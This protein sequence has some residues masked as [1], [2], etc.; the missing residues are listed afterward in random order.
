MD[1][2]GGVGRSEG[3]RGGVGVPNDADSFGL[4][5][6]ATHIHGIL[7]NRDTMW[8]A[9]SRSRAQVPPPDPIPADKF[10]DSFSE[11]MDNMAS[12]ATNEKAVLE[13]LFTKTTTQYAAI[14]ALLK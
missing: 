10:I 4:A 7:N 5:N 1:V 13:Q 2:H 14:K 9:T 11:I 12:T 8:P 6:A 3:I